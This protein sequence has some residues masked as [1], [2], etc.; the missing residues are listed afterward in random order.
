MANY[1]YLIRGGTIIDGSGFPRAKGD[2]GISGEYIKTV[3]GTEKGNAA[4]VIDA[5]GK[6]LI[7]GIVDITNH[8][9]THWTLFTYP[10]QCNL[11]AQGI[12]TIIGGAC[13]ASI[14]P[15]VETR[16]IQS[17]KKWTDISRANINWQS[18]SELFDELERH[19]LGVN[20]GMFV[21]YSTLRGNITD[22]ALQELTRAELE[23]VKLILTRSLDEGALGLSFGLASLGNS[24]AL[25]DEVIALARVV[26]DAGKVVTVH[27]RNEGSRLL[28]SIVEALRI[29]RATG[30]PVHI[31]HIKAIGRRAWQD[32]NKALAI[33]Q[34]AR[35]EENLSITVDLFPYLRTGSLLYNFLPDWILE[36]GNSKIIE[37][38][39]DPS[40]RQ[41]V[42]DSMKKQTLHYDK[43]VIAEA[44][45]SKDVVGK[46]I[47]HIAQSGG[48]SPEETV[49]EILISNDLG[50]T[51]FSKTLMS[52]HLVSIAREPYSMFSSDGVGEGERKRDLTHPRSYGAFPRF[53]HRLVVKGNI[54]SWE[55]AVKKMTSV[56]ASL[57]GLGSHR[58][59]LKQGYFADVVILDPKKIIDMATY[60][61]PYQYPHGIDYVFVNGN[62]AFKKGKVTGA[63]A[64][65][66]F[67]RS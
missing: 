24:L 57:V 12:T 52:T 21:G 13:G 37:I 66:V 17:I 53:L 40:K 2:L 41:S 61:H 10:E 31:S 64:G 50:V 18:V 35:K 47:Q 14:A 9:D 51:V 44:Q 26:A 46:T 7:P 49:I 55:E 30:V 67:R 36:G 33:V 20:F 34:K 38:L 3:G 4:E 63:L 27:L 54:L 29:A 62:C 23:S 16:A 28:P 42:L 45:K 6:Y 65:K 25:Q 39:I 48:L 22:D 43:I 58:G 15:L 1:T 59:L 5:T 11:L 60:R 19:P 56:P 8:S 32:F